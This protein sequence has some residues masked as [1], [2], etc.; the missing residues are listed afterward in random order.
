MPEAPG[1]RGTSGREPASRGRLASSFARSFVAVALVALIAAGLTRALAPAATG[2]SAAM[3]VA[4]TTPSD[5]PASERVA[6]YLGVADAV[7]GTRAMVRV[8]RDGACPVDRAQQ[9]GSGDPAWNWLANVRLPAGTYRAEVFV[10]VPTP[11][12]M[13]T[14]D[15]VAWTVEAG[16]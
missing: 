1:G 3:I 14:A 11:F 5:V 6:L 16:P 9:I 12:G 4:A 10:Q 13:R 15:A 2:A 8:C 7:P